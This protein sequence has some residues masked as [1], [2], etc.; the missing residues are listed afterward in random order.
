MSLVRNRFPSSV[1]P[2]EV[3]PPGPP[4][5]WVSTHFLEVE[6][7]LADEFH[8][9]SQLK[10]SVPNSVRPFTLDLSVVS[11]Q[12]KLLRQE[13]VYDGQNS[14]LSLVLASLILCF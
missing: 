9:P 10:S 7:E 12:C 13:F 4:Y 2:L 5:A 14:S 6:H 1:P 11:R 3:P 8:V